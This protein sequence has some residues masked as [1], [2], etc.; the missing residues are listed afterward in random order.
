MTKQIKHLIH[1]Q[2]HHSDLIHSHSGI[3]IIR[4]IDQI[5]S[6]TRTHFNNSMCFLDRS[7]QIPAPHPYTALQSFLHLRWNVLS[8]CGAGD[9]VVSTQSNVSTLHI[10]RFLIFER[11]TLAFVHT[12]TSLSLS[13]DT[14]SLSKP[15]LARAHR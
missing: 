10:T 11:R 8:S 14:L 9:E 7:K 2:F 4:V 5:T 3:L 12:H 13:I 6:D 1:S 15:S